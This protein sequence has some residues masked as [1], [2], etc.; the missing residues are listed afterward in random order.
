MGTVR[1]QWEGASPHAGG[2]VEEFREQMLTGGSRVQPG[3]A[4]RPS[5]DVF[6]VEDGLLVLADLAGVHQSDI[7][8]QAGRLHISGARRR[9]PVA[10]PHARGQLG[11]DY[12]RFERTIGPGPEIEEEQI[13][14]EY[15]IALL[16]VKLPA[17]TLRG[18]MKIRV[19]D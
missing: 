9:P 11:I 5:V 4:W 7:T 3:P 2:A 6:E 17:A 12:G 13:S 18:R 10:G 15:R 14:A 1:Q 8:V 16:L 19:E